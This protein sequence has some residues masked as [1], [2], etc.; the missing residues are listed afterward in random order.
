MRGGHRGAVVLRVALAGRGGGAG[1]D[2]G[3]D[4]RA[5][6]GDVHGRAVVGE[7]GAVAVGV[8][9]RH[10]DGVLAVGRTGQGGIPVLVA[11][12][13]HHRHAAADGRVDGVLVGGAARAG[14]AQ[15]HVDHVHRGRVVR[16]AGDGAAGGPHDGVRD[17][18][19]GAAAL[20]EHAGVLDLGVRGD[21]DDALR[22]GHGRDGAGHVGAVPRGVRAQGLAA[23]TGQEPV[24]LVRRV[25]VAAAAVAGDRGARDEVVAGDGVGV[26]V[27]VIGLTG[28][29]DA[30]DHAGAGGGVPRPGHAHAVDAGEAPLLR[31]EGVHRGQRVRGHDGVRLDGVDRAG[32]L[33]VR[34]ERGG[35]AL[36]Q[37]A[38]GLDHVGA[39]RGLAQLL[40]GDAGLLGGLAPRVRTALGGAVRGGLLVGDDERV[41]AVRVGLGRGRG[42]AAVR[43]R[44]DGGGPGPVVRLG[45]GG[46]R[47]GGE[48][49]AGE[50]PGAQEGAGAAAGAE[51]GGGRH[52]VSSV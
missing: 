10:G 33:Q 42:H 38:V 1:V 25:R 35:L 37:R 50:D 40:H 2:R 51:G 19:Q 15:G 31:V 13:H 9:G 23:L 21:A 8:R 45:G 36:V 52:R 39:E 5:R 27:G 6:G 12:G 29:D 22:V 3:D 28:V 17:V 26:E 14:P 24:A 34:H 46:G 41:V 32:G 49:A 30:H 7:G 11:G 47:R 16:H 48:R 43:R 44:G 4:G 20:A 18:R